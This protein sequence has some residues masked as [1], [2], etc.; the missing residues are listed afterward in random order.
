MQEKI[1]HTSNRT[2]AVVMTRLSAADAESQIITMD[3]NFRKNSAN[4]S[5]A[6]T[7]TDVAIPHTDAIL[8]SIEDGST[9]S[10]SP[11]LVTASKPMPMTRK[12]F[13][14]RIWIRHAK[15]SCTEAD[16]RP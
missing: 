16:V 8:A 2:K 10:D 3:T 6:L 13:E 12:K 15:K 4:V 5:V 14:L 7:A 1:E 11:V 9:F